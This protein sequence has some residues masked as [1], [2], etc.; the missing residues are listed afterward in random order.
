MSMN[1]V[2]SLLLATQEHNQP[3]GREHMFAMGVLYTTAQIMNEITTT[4]VME[5]QDPTALPVVRG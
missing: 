4:E 3:C 2:V 1:T 5:T